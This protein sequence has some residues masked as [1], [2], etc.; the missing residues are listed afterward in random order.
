MK[1]TV[2]IRVDKEDVNKLMNKGVNILIAEK[3]ELDGL[4]FTLK[5]MFKRAVK[6]YVNEEQRD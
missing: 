4:N 3:P 1:N 5:Y 2:S 6:F